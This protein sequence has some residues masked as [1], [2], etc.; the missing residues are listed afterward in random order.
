MP[1]SDKWMKLLN[2]VSNDAGNITK[3]ETN[4]LMEIVTQTGG[5]DKYADAIE[6]KGISKYRI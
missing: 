3:E 4:K 2:F 6:K 5:I 1:D